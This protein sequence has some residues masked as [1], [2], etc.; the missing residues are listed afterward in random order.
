MLQLVSG[1]V[2]SPATLFAPSVARKVLSRAAVNS[3]TGLSSASRLLMTLLATFVTLVPLHMAARAI[4]AWC[5]LCVLP[6][7]PHPQAVSPSSTGPVTLLDSISHVHLL[8]QLLVACTCSTCYAMYFSARLVVVRE[9]IS[10]SQ[11]A[12]TNQA[13]LCLNFY[14]RSHASPSVSNESTW[15]RF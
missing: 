5:A 4:H 2:N 6:S 1:F 14:S 13:D 11:P 15:R 3:W 7:T 9:L 10:A 12:W 8:W